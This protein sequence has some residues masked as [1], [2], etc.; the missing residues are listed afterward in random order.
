METFTLYS[1]G[2]ALARF[3]VQGENITKSVRDM[4]GLDFLPPSP[5][6][7]ADDEAF[8]SFKMR[9]F[10]LLSL[11][12]SFEAAAQGA[13]EEWTVDG[14][15][16]TRAGCGGLLSYIHRGVK[17]PSN[18]LFEN[19]R[20]IAWLCPCREQANILVC[21]G[22]E[23]KTPLA[24]WKGYA[25]RPLYGVDGP[26]TFSVTTRDGVGLATDVY[27]PAGAPLPVPALLVRTPYD[28]DDGAETYFRYVR[29][30]YAVVVQDVRGRNESGGE[31][32][33]HYYEI[34]DGDDTLTWVGTQDWCTGRVG[35]LGGSYLGYTQWCAAAL[36]NPHLKA[37]I[38]V[39]TAGTA[40]TDSPMHGGCLGS[41]G[42]A[43][44]FSMT[45]QRYAPERME[46]DDWDEVLDIRP[47]E[48]IGPKALG[49]DVPFIRKTLAHPCEDDFWLHGNWVKRNAGKT[50]PVLI[51]SGWFDDNGMGTTEALD[52]TASYPAG[53]RK[54]ILGPWQHGG[55][56]Q[57]DLHALSFGANAL[58]FDLD[59]IYLQWFDHF[60]RGEENGV[61]HTA[62]V[63]YYTMGTGEWKTAAQW[64]VEHADDTPF[65]FGEGGTLFP[66]SGSA[67][68]LSY[69]Y[70]PKNPGTHIIDMCENEIAVPEDYT[71]E[72]KR[73][74]Y[75][76]YTT[77]P[78]REPLTVT[79]DAR[80][81]LYISSDAPDTDFMVRLCDVDENGR[82]VKIA[83]GILAARFRNGFAKS[84]YLTPGKVEKLVIRTSKVS[85]CFQPGHR[86]RV[87]V[88][89]GAKNFVFPNSNTKNG[90]NSIET[91]IAHNS[92]WHGG[93]TPSHILLHVER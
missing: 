71:E 36:G 66:I 52:L 14:M 17:Y 59:F 41:G 16:Y 38:S 73:P 87:S 25:D 12:A 29:R 58:R 5:M 56:S 79:G 74:D 9:P 33:P 44:M 23:E 92:V 40:M 62:P 39:V 11:R 60:L 13:P 67:G 42:F 49:E 83:D 48:D 53:M 64:P 20:V 68:H 63:E 57:Y 3:T 45:K 43:W 27:L 24:L 72:E 76:L 19:G 6:S 7:A 31:W 78:L 69:A 4:R 88:T 80:A 32:L 91:R 22:Y 54:V 81:V 15:R 28:R 18:A 35:T 50:V 30:G 26:H 75:L 10:H 84:E 89:S 37:M 86:L 65:Y 51:Q 47:L 8:S 55:N 82:S 93:D 70:D 46:R 77:P 85:H 90:Y 34:E 2:I 1:S 61:E 21:D